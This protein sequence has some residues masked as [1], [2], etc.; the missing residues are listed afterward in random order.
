MRSRFRCWVLFLSLA[1][2]SQAYGQ[3]FVITGKVDFL[4]GKFVDLVEYGDS[5]RIALDISNPVKAFDAGSLPEKSFYV[6]ATF[7]V[8]GRSIT[9]GATATA[10]VAFYNYAD[11]SPKSSAWDGMS[12]LFNV[13][14]GNHSAVATLVTRDDVLNSPQF[15]PPGLPLDTFD[16]S[17]LRGA[18]SEPSANRVG[19]TIDGYHYEG[20]AL[21]AVPESAGYGVLAAIALAGLLVRRVRRK[22]A[23]PA[24][25]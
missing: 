12:V 13:G 8:G 6:P 14:S 23:L 25:V 19:Y 2:G 18:Y 10:L 24:T 3:L 16:S 9:P 11:G 17:F 15:L 4:Q 20:L 22:N 5:V 7:E 21:T 1:V